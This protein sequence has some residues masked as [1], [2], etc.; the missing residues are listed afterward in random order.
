M[1]V[2]VEHVGRGIDIDLFWWELNTDEEDKNAFETQMDVACSIC[3]SVGDIIRHMRI[4]GFDV[5]LVEI[6]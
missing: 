2:H 4:N 1:N 3:S 5:E 6:Y